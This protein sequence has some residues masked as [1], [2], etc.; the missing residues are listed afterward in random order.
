MDGR[1][2][3]STGGY[4]AA[5]PDSQRAPSFGTMK[6]VR[7]SESVDALVEYKG[8]RAFPVLKAIKWQGR[9]IGF[10]TLGVVERV[11]ST[12]LYRFDEGF[13]RFL[14]RFEPARQAWYLEGIDDS[15]TDFPPPRV[16]PP[17]NWRR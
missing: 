13:T 3:S 15:G 4:Y 2:L 17:T 6:T 9:R 10:E 12:L 16:F 7:V 11:G 14:V 8:G 5:P 1:L